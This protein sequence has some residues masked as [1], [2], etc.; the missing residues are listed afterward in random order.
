[1][2]EVWNR[3]K[4]A[5]DAQIENL[6]VIRSRQRHSEPAGLSNKIL[7]GLTTHVTHKAM[8]L[9]KEQYDIF[10]R[11]KR[12]AADPNNHEY[13]ETE[14][15]NTYFKSTGILCWHMI[16]DR[17]ESGKPIQPLDFHPH[18]LLKR[19]LPG[20]ELPPSP[21]EVILDPVSRRARRNVEAERRAHARAHQKELRKSRTGRILSQFEQVQRTLRHCSACVALDHNKALC[22]GCKSTDHTRRNCP[23]E[24]T[25]TGLQALHRNLQSL[26]GSRSANHEQIIPEVADDSLE[27]LEDGSAPES[28]QPAAKRPRKARVSSKNGPQSRLLPATQGVQAQSTPVQ[29]LDGHGYFQSAVQRIGNMDPPQSRGYYMNPPPSTQPRGYGMANFV[30]GSEASS[31]LGYVNP[32]QILH[33][34]TSYAAPYPSFPSSQPTI[35]P[36]PTQRFTQPQ[37]SPRSTSTL[38]PMGM[39]STQ[40]Y[41][42][43][44][45]SQ[46]SQYPYPP[47]SQSF[48]W[49]PTSNS[50]TFGGGHH[51]ANLQ[52][53]RGGHANTQGRP[54]NF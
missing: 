41:V 1:M 45:G 5:I 42:T 4:A 27:E 46:S 48:R 19:P 52:G 47:P 33:P 31:E 32:R 21:E 53:H 10:E 43:A 51:M 14:C 22:Q 9:L 6:K 15:S 18:W 36:S 3:T 50:Q 35:P 34:Q 12:H 16:R 2:T 13:E 49:D 30:P 25:E 44:A 39:S 26:I 37:L 54:Y 8:Y 17:I 29:T 40:E 23:Q 24:P 38:M 20:A 28:T 11:N 7:A